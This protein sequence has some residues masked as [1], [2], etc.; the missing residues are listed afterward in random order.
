MRGRSSAADGRLNG[1]K[2]ISQIVVCVSRSQDI[3]HHELITPAFKPGKKRIQYIALGFSPE[4]KNKLMSYVQVWI[5]AVW[6]TKNRYPFMN[7]ESKEAICSFITTYATEKQIH[8]DCI[9]GH[10]DHLHCLFGLNADLPLSKH[11]QLL[12]GGSAFWVNNKSNLFTTD[13]GWADDYFA[14][15][16][17]K[18]NLN[19]VRNYIQNQEVH[20]QTTTV[21]LIVN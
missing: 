2:T 1:C 6:G 21:V 7:H 9:N 12:K 5:H 18:D 20:H 10:W 8:I 4:N 14:A 11:L 19:K 16:V 3:Y 13:F 15:S 17:S